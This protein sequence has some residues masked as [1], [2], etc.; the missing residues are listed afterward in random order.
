MLYIR[1]TITAGLALAAGSLV[2]GV[3]TDAAAQANQFRGNA[4]IITA[5][6]A[7]APN[8]WSVGSCGAARFAPPNWNGNPNRTSISFYWGY[9]A[10]NFSNTAGSLVG[11]VFRPVQG[12][13]IAN[14][15]FTYTGSTARI[16]GQIPAA[17][18]ATTPFLSST[19]FINRFDNIAGCNVALRFQGQR[20]PL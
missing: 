3:V 8:G 19:I 16:G 12:G 5:T 10:Q 4:C 20:Y 15:I 9:Y 6:A 1:S 17:P 7:C 11:T 13:G 18:V 14:G 2:G